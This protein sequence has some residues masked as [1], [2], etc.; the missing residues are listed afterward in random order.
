MKIIEICGPPCSGKTYIY[1][2]L[3]KKLKNISIDYR[4]LVPLYSS[5]F[6]SLNFFEKIILF[7]LIKN[8]KKNTNFKKKKKIVK[9]NRNYL[10]K[11]IYEINL[12]IH[13][14]LI[15]FFK[16]K[17][18]IILIFENKKTNHMIKNYYKQKTKYHQRWY[19]EMIVRYYIAKYISS[20]K[21]ILFDEG[22]IQRLSILRNIDKNNI[23]LNKILK[24]YNFSNTI[25]FLNS[26]ADLIYKRSNKR[27]VFDDKYIYNDKKEVY[28][29]KSYFSNAKKILKSKNVKIISIN[30]KKF[31][32]NKLVQL[33][34]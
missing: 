3:N 24:K 16:R 6:I 32:L 11:I 20:K 18:K 1:N 31:D 19:I 2:L 14:K 25:I 15:S 21:I 26:S 29:F 12:N 4:L 9:R 7:L 8:H 5:N 13:N 17:E 30:P 33:I 23:I 34:S 28:K 10:H 22:F 27:N